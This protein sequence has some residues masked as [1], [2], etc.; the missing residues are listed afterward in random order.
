MKR[1]PGVRLAVLRAVSD[2]S[3]DERYP[4]VIELRTHL[5]SS[6]GSVWYNL[7]ALLASGLLRQVGGARGLRLTH[8]GRV[9]LAHD[10][11]YPA[12]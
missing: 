6:T 7:Q 8:A 10:A 11:L 1:D 3:R 2:L 12:R 9:A 5:D 4:S